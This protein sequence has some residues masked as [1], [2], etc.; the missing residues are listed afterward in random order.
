MNPQ[1]YFEFIYTTYDRS[2]TTEESLCED[3]ELLKEIKNEKDMNSFIVGLFETCTKYADTTQFGAAALNILIN[4]RKSDI[5]FYNIIEIIW[6]KECD[7][8]SSNSSKIEKLETGEKLQ[9]TMSRVSLM[10]YLIAH[11]VSKLSDIE[12]ISCK[13]L[14]NILLNF[15]MDY[16]LKLLKSCAKCIYFHQNICDILSLSGIDLAKL[17]YKKM[18][19][20]VMCLQIMS[21]YEQIPHDILVNT[22]KVV[23]KLLVDIDNCAKTAIFVSTIRKSLNESKINEIENQNLSS[24]TCDNYSMT[25]EDRK[26]AQEYSETLDDDL[27]NMEQFANVHIMNDEEE[28]CYDAFLA[29]MK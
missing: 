13:N 2:K 18:S 12:K 1:K 19:D 17:D 24:P 20:I 8:I 15:L 9:E 25:Q 14:F 23:S 28:R 29:D 16:I 7:S 10:S 21:K 5:S 4:K 22:K 26:I 27:D 3:D 6:I 11:F